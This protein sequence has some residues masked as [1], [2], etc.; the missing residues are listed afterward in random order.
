MRLAI[1]GATG[2]VGSHFVER[3]L[4]AGHQVVGVCNSR[5]PAK[6]ELRAVL[7]GLGAKLVDGDI[8]EPASLRSA[9]KGANCVC[10]FAAA[11]RESGM[12]DEY[13]LRLN[14]QG[15]INV[16]NA[17]AAEGARRFV[18]CSTA[19]IYGQ[20]VAGTIT[21]DS[22]VRP[23]NVYERSK[24]EA[25]QAI[26]DLAPKLG[27]QYVILRPA[28]VYGPRDQRL[29]K[30]FRSAAKGRFPSL[31]QVRVGD[32]WSMSQTSRTHS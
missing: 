29:L 9:T 10:H 23:W 20:R 2:F 22:P 8:M 21:E 4:G 12:S 6:Q 13:F 31:E 5:A 7:T 19:G 26:R 17:A 30:L 32:T 28:A 18:M 24:V 15:T 14:V 16:L 3:A 11:F 27:M 1:T 25:E